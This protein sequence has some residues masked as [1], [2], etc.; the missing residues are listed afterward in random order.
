MQE[1]L[2]KK[3]SLKMSNEQ[4]YDKCQSC[5]MP[6][7]KNKNKGTNSDQSLSSKYCKYCYQD[8]EFVEPNFGLKEMQEMC[9]K[10]FKDH[11]PIM[12]VFFGKSY[13][14]AIATGERWSKENN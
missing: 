14:K 3:E 7:K 5:M 10:N 2:M 12:F 11:H 8:G 9:A 6:I 1:L 4:V 13:V